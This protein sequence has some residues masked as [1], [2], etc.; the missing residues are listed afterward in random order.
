VPLFEY[1][2]FDAPRPAKVAGTIEGAGR[3]AVSQ[4]LREQ[5]GVPHRPE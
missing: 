3:K 1:A 2:G 4:A 5:G